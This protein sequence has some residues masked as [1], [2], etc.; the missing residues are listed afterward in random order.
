MPQRD[1]RRIG[2]AREHEMNDIFGHVVLAI[3]VKDLGAEEFVHSILLPLGS[4]FECSARQHLP[5]GTR[6]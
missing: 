1:F 2:Q 5:D 4:G 6:R 3:G